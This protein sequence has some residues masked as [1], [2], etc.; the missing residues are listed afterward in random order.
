MLVLP[1]N[2][3]LIYAKVANTL[4]IHTAE[5]N[6]SNNSIVYLMLFRACYISLIADKCSI[7][8]IISNIGRQNIL[9][10]HF[11]S[12]G[13]RNFTSAFNSPDVFIQMRSI[14]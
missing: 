12:H 2:N 1:G 5:N 7:I 6:N 4:L 11:H 14:I 10:F 3:N 13:V 8:S 9:C